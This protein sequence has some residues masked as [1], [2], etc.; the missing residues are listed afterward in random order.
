MFSM[1]KYKIITLAFTLIFSCVI[2]IAQTTAHKLDGLVVDPYKNQAIE[3][4]IVTITGLD[5]SLKT[6]KDGRFKAEI[7]LEDAVVKVWYPGYYS[8]EQPVANRKSIKFVL[9]PESKAGYSD[10]FLL[11]FKGLTNAREKQTNLYSIQ[12]NDINLNKTDV[13]QMLSNM[14]GMQVIAK[15]GMPGEGYFFERQ[16]QQYACW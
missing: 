3:G 1:N 7:E 6:D 11:P 2:A 9:I 16:R 10:N 8:A 4:A 15:S 14:P 5:G 13:E 12:K